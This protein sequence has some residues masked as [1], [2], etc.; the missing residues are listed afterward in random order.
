M[1]M[2]YNIV[3]C[4]LSLSFYKEIDEMYAR[5]PSC[6][7]DIEIKRKCDIDLFLRHQKT[8]KYQ[9]GKIN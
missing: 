3:K 7:R 6:F 4:R 2:I 1:K 5:V 8:A 9:E